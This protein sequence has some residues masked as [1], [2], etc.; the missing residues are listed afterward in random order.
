MP[1]EIK[2]QSARL[3]NFDKFLLFLSILV[4]IEFYI[5]S[6]VQ[7]SD[8]VFF[9]VQIADTFICFVFMYDFFRGLYHADN[10]WKYWKREWIQFV[11]SI[12]FLGFLRVGRLAKILRILRLVRSGKMIASIFNKYDSQS[13]FLNVLIINLIFIF[14]ISVSFYTFEH[15]TNPYITDIM[16]S[17][18]WCIHV[19]IA[20]GQPKNAPYMTPDGQV[21]F[22]TISLIRMI[23][24]GTLIGMITDFFM[25]KY[26][27][28][29]STEPVV[30]NY[31]I[32]LKI[33]HLE[34]KIVQLETIIR[35][36]F[37]QQEKVETLKQ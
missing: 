28:Q 26:K 27:K 15:E 12:P 18:W 31:E 3:S 16:S 2:T 23:L 10:K 20:F 22:L 21:I 36:N 14:L 29:K 5:S 35:N 8:E 17:F 13:T 6:I 37:E 19:L 4:V 34:E 25:G 9:W 32:S 24:F 1:E 33:N 7:Y 30:S 11:S